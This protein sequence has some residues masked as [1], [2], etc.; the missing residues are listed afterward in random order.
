MFNQFNSERYER[1]WNYASSNEKQAELE[2]LGLHYKAIA[3][4]LPM[5]QMPSS[6]VATIL[7]SAEYFS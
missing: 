5:E 3:T 7:H 6:D 1:S 4:D 2:R